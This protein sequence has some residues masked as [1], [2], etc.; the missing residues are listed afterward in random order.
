M[1]QVLNTRPLEE[2]IKAMINTPA[3]SRIIKESGQELRQ[4][5]VRPSF[6]DGSC[7]KVSTILLQFYSVKNDELQMNPSCENMPVT[8]VKSR[9]YTFCPIS[10]SQ[11]A[12][13]IPIG[14]DL[15][16][17]TLFAFDLP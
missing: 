1:F 15:S 13:P 4:V 14:L 2:K 11:A 17:T 8:V 9:V 16:E 10:T 5:Q 7:K 12:V 6:A 3:S